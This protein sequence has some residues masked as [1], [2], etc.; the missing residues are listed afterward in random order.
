VFAGVDTSGATQARMNFN[1]A[2]VHAGDT[3]SYRFNGGPWR[4]YLVPAIVDTESRQG[5][6]VPVMVTDLVA[7]DNQVE[8]GTTGTAANMPGSSMHVANIDLEL[9]AP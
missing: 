7:G 6:S 8:F 3:L 2:Y 9:E 5:F 1:T 4:D